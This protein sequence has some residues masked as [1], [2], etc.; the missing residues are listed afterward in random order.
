MEGGTLLTSVLTND[1]TINSKNVLEVTSTN[2]LMSLKL[3]TNGASAGKVSGSF[4]Y[5]GTGKKA[6][7]TISGVVLQQQNEAVGYFL[8]QRKRHPHPQIKSGQ[9]LTPC[10]NSGFPQEQDLV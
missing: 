8:D 9:I 7:T 5:P 1:V 4:D 10:G 2:Y 6:D 3:T